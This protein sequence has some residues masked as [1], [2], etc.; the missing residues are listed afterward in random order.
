MT[1][2]EGSPGPDT[3]ATEP[4]PGRSRSWWPVLAPAA[5]FLIGL[6][7]GGL[8]VGVVSDDDGTPTAEQEP[9]QSTTMTTDGASPSPSPGDT[10]VVVPEECLAAVDTVEEALDLADRSAGAIR[11]FQPDEL[12]SLLRELEALDQEARAQAEACQ[13][14]QADVEGQ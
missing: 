5:A 3:T 2:H 14:V 10:T 11:D 9:D 4:Q 1:E 8:L 12:R 13:Q 7:L 6:L